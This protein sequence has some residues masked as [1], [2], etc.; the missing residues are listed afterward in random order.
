V[1]YLAPV[2][3]DLAN[4]APKHR[5]KTLQDA[6]DREKEAMG[7]PELPL[8]V[9]ANMLAILESG[10]LHMVNND[11][12]DTGANPFQFT[13]NPN[14]VSAKSKQALYAAVLGRG[15]APSTQEMQDLM[16]A[17]F[18]Q[19]TH[20]HIGGL[21][22]NEDSGMLPPRRVGVGSCRAGRITQVQHP[23]YHQMPGA[24]DPSQD[25]CSA[26]RPTE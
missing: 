22:T 9:Q 16:A 10:S 15:M 6:I 11:A 5:L 7:E 25:E 24:G 14:I 8:V 4:S 2:Y 19:G 20:L 13:A 12:V 1:A 21:T 17:C 3:D 26:S 23:P 18:D